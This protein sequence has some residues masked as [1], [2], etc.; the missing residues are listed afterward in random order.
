MVEAGYDCVWV[1]K[2]A[3]ARRI[4]IPTTTTA[5]TTA[6]KKEERVLAGVPPSSKHDSFLS[7]RVR[8]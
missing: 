4:R 3:H 7:S 8:R 2:I 1:H 5:S 6:V